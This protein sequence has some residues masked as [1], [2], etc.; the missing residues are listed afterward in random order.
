MF[1]RL[2]LGVLLLLSAPGLDIAEAHTATEVAHTSEASDPSAASKAGHGGALGP[3]DHGGAATHEKE[4]TEETEETEEEEEE[5]EEE[6]ATIFSL[7]AGFSV[8]LLAGL[9]CMLILITVAYEVVTDW[10]E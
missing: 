9:L 6:E 4:G 7:E 5:E 8:Q 10:L 3:S 1:A 2:L